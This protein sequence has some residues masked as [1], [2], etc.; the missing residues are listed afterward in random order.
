MKHLSTEILAKVMNR[1]DYVN[2]IDRYTNISRRRDRSD[3]FVPTTDTIFLLGEYLSGDMGYKQVQDEIK[4]GSVNIYY[5]LL[6]TCKYLYNQGDLNLPIVVGHKK[7]KKPVIKI[8][9]ATTA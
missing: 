2:L 4:Q 5:T 8:T 6:Q 1:E 9:K 7:K 3:E